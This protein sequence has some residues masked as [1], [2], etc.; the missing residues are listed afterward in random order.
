MFAE[1]L[2]TVLI[3]LYIFLATEAFSKVIII[4]FEVILELHLT[5]A[6]SSLQASTLE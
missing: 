2:N 4:C 6:E 5:N 1:I 3:S